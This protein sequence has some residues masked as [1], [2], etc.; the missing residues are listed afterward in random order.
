MG[1]IEN[2]TDMSIFITPNQNEERVAG[3]KILVENNGDERY[4]VGKKVKVSFKGD[5]TKTSP[6][7]INLVSIDI[8]D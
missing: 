2:I 3:A 6:Q 4:K 1:T 8:L 7:N 5:I